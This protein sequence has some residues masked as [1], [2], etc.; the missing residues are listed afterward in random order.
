[1]I[2]YVQVF[3]LSLKKYKYSNNKS[4]IIIIIP[5]NTQLD[6]ISKSHQMS[7]VFHRTVQ[8]IQ[9]SNGILQ[10]RDHKEDLQD[11]HRPTGSHAQRCLA[12][13][14]KIDSMIPIHVD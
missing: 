2:A 8:C 7:Y 11:I 10:S 3:V 13:K 5:T 9:G 1:M 4:I 6:N 14:L 12:D